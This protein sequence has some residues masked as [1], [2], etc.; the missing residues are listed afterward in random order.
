MGLAPAH[1]EGD[2]KAVGKWWILFEDVFTIPW[3]QD[4]AFT[5]LSTGTE[6]TTEVSK[7]LL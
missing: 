6:A 2:I 4:A 1:I 5:S 7:D 3:K